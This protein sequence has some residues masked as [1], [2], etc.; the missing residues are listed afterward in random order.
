MFDKTDHI[1]GSVTFI[2]DEYDDLYRKVSEISQL[3]NNIS[4]LQLSVNAINNRQ[5]ETELQLDQ[6][7]QYGRRENLEI[8][9]I[10]VTKNENT[11]RIVKDLAISLNVELDDTHISTCHRMPS[12]RTPRNPPRENHKQVRL[13]LETFPAHNIPQSLSGFP[14]ETKETNFMEKANYLTKFSL[15]KIILVSLL[16][17]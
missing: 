15:T 1:L 12:P 8:H 14:I 6:L 3:S 5:T 2:A 9:G 13:D 11:R 7:E 16:P 10:P 4:N 17:K